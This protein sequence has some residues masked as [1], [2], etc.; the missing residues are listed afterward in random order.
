M[1]GLSPLAVFSLALLILFGGYMTYEIWRWTMGRA[2]GLTGGQLV[3]RLAG[4]LLIEAALV[5]WFMSD[6]V[7]AGRPPLWRLNYLLVATLMAVVAMIFAVREAAF[8]ARQYIRQRR[9]L[10]GRITRRE[11]RD[12]SPNG[13]GRK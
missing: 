10:V 4:G 12:A 9:D 7:F 11:A 5:M 1:G 3:R 13:R 8:V 2:P 6:F